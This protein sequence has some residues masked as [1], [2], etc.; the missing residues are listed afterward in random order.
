MK[1]VLAAGLAA[2]MSLCLAGCGSSSSSAASSSDSGIDFA[3]QFQDLTGMAPDTT[4]LSVN[5]TDVTAVEYYYQAYRILYNV[6][7]SYFSTETDYN[8]IT[9]SLGTNLNTYV[10]NN[11]VS[12]KLLQLKAAEVGVTLSDDDKSAVE[13][14]IQSYLT[15]SGSEEAFQQSLLTNYGLDE[16]T[17]REVLEEQYLYTAMEDYYFGT[18][19]QTP[20]TDADVQTYITD[21]GCYKV[22]YILLY[23]DTYT[24]DEAQS[25]AADLI[26][27]L[28]ASS[29]PS[30]LMDSLITQYS[31][32]TGSAGE[33]TSFTTGQCVSEF[34][35]AAL[36]LGEGE[37]TAAPVY[38]SS[39]G[40]FIIQRLPVSLDDY[41]D[42]VMGDKFDDL[43]ETW[44]SA[45]TVT[46]A[47]AYSQ[48][49]YQTYFEN[50]M[51]LAAAA[52]T[53]AQASTS[54]ATDSA[55]SSSSSAT[56]SSN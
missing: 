3:A 56:T 46:N 41:R 24:D 37:I 13:S 11:A 31:Y 42:T 53:D 25:L 15:S 8:W 21:N 50:L 36:A 51:A 14:T 48:I 22:K 6:Y 52:S 7:Q 30:S 26:G 29:D 54:S 1:K 18:S 47:D 44:V 32:D 16:D 33:G 39:Y 34:E 9:D 5:G 27:Q 49:N 4:V 55:A 28:Q 10:D 19:G 38:S 2:A 40:Y 35:T 45:A 23:K 43:M 12:S 20:V 17:C